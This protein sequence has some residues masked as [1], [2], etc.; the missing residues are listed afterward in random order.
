M[1]S[2]RVLHLVTEYI[3]FPN[4]PGAFIKIDHF[5]G[6]KTQLHKFKR[7]EIIQYLLLDHN[8]VKLEIN[9]INIDGRIPKYL[10]RSDSTLLDNIRVK[11]EISREIE[12]YFELNEN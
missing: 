2:Y 1:D 9:N 4:S 11:K 6:H 8:N 5:L 3:L 12:K 7:I 10:G